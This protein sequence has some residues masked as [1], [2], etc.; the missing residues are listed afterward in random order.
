[1]NV[2]RCFFLGVYIVDI[3][4]KFTWWIFFW[5]FTWIGASVRLVFKWIGGLMNIL[6]FLK[7]C[8]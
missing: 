2:D 7:E 6:W 3:F 4:W 1:M 5:M 8:A